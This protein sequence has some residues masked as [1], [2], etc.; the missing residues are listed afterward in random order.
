[1]PSTIPLSLFVLA[2]GLLQPATARADGW[3]QA[4][5]LT[6]IIS[7]YPVFTPDG[8]RV[9]FQSN[10][11]GRWEIYS[12]AIDGTDVRQLTNE[13][14]DNVTPA[15]SP[16]GGWIAFAANPGGESDIF[17][18]RADGT[19]RRQLT[20]HPGDDSHP[21]W[22]PD[23]ERLAFN[24]A[25]TTPDP[26]AEWSRQ[27]H[28]V[29]SMRPDGSDLRQ[30]TTCR[31]VC[32]YPVPSPEGDRIV[33]RKITDTPGYQWNLDSAARNSEVFVAG[34]DG[35][36]EVN[37]S[38]SAAF[39]GWPTWTPDGDVVFASNRAGPANVG[40][41]FR[42]AADGT[43]L[44]QLTGGAWSHVQ[45]AVAPGGAQLLAYRNVETDRDEFGDVVLM[46]LPARNRD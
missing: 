18:M 45:A 20:D 10:R 46:D 32:T 26:A 29:F 15:V 38:N 24:S 11:S 28:E 30:H 4:V 33:Y 43:N 31:S 27:W 37:L 22:F 41:L 42:V 23:G 13:P 12:M 35:S 5:R 25:R 7:S 40:Q 34:L 9:V 2:I 16:D 39:D 17:L 21:H 3:P 19:D 1:M 36:G 6:N 14:G 44:R 8:R